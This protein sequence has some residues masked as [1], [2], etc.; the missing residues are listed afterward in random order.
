MHRA[1]VRW[2]RGAA[3]VLLA[4]LAATIPRVAALAQA[5]RVAEVDLVGASRI[6][7]ETIL[8]VIS[9]K[10]GDEVSAERLERDR[11]AIEALG[12]FKVVGP[13]AVS[14]VPGGTR[15][16]FV[17]TEWPLLKT[18][19]I[20]GNTVIREAQIRERIKTKTDQ[21]FNL[22]QWQAD[23]AAIESLYRERSFVA[24]VLDNLDTQEFAETGILKVQ[25]LELAIESIKIEGLHKTKPYVVRRVLRQRAGRLYN[26]Q[27]MAKDYQELRRLDYFEAIN[28]RVDVSQPGKVVVTWEVK[29]KRTGQASVGLGYSP[30]ES[31][32]GRA[33]VSE[34]NLFGKGQSVSVGAEI[35]SQ[36]GGPSFEMSFMEP[37]LTADRTS[38]GVSL[39]NKLVY[40]FSSSLGR[41]EGQ[42]NELGRYFER[43][44]GGQLTLGRPFKW[45]VTAT[46]RAEQVDTKDL[47]LKADFPRQDGLVT[48]LALRHVV[49]SRDY[50]NHPTSGGL[51]SITVEPGYVSLEPGATESFQT[52]VFNKLVVDLRRY[53]ALKRNPKTK[54]PEREQAAQKIPV[55]AFRLM[56]GT[57]IGNLPFF[58]Q[59]FLGGSES[60]RGYT[61]DRFWGN[62]VLLASVE[63]R[64]PMGNRITAVLFGDV[65]DAWGSESEFQ[66]TNKKLRTEFVQTS[67][68][69]L[70]PSLGLGLRVATPIGPIRLD[71]G[72]GLEG[73]RVHFSI[74]N[75]F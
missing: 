5:G 70:Q 57:S 52:A 14:Q 45:P 38:L 21:V 13:P 44:F 64:R 17:V 54:E 15:V 32:V 12:W 61:E 49:N 39:Y 65:G 3:I 30:R 53:V 68:L 2:R 8:A 7:R 16:V 1:S 31:V 19:E 46:F 60:L 23:V 62:N 37:F 25:V 67:G 51:N 11:R 50:V 34:S 59:F 41:V 6:N 55:L 10:P 48:G 63:Y 40:R 58:E 18:I 74:G 22:A 47:P 71:Y 26:T 43:R 4:M 73:G 56:G 42:K 29:E 72:Y 33:E 24:Q 66:F 27:K 20:G 75:S 69:Q 9:T 36:L 28:S 35:G